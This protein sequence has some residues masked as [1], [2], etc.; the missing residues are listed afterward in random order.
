M[1]CGVVCWVVVCG[2]GAGL[3]PITAIAFMI[4]A[5]PN[6]L[7][8][9][10]SVFLIVPVLVLLPFHG[11]YALALVIAGRRPSYDKGLYAASKWIRKR[12]LWSPFEA[13]KKSS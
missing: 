3:G 1:L 13:Q 11:L 7:S 6:L 2:A 10:Y 5:L 8:A 4:G 9:V 12:P